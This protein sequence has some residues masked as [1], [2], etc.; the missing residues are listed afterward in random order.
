MSKQ[1]RSLLD[2]LKE[3]AEV[4]VS[5]AALV[6]AVAA[7]VITLEQTK[8]MREEAELERRNARIGVM[9]SVWVGTHIG[10]SAG[11]AYFRIVLTNKG[12][13]PAVIERVDVDYKGKP[14]GN[15]DEL[16]RRMAADLGSAKD[17]EGDVLFSSR[18]PVSPGLMLEAGGDAVPLNVVE[19]GD[20]EG[21][22]LLIRGTPHLQVTLCYCSLYGDCFRTEL[23]RRPQQ[24]DAC[25][26]A[27]KPFIS[28]GFFR[29]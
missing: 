17:F 4:L 20:A 14:V 26:A 25:E 13:G 29:N 24:V 22:K 16:A 23:F 28:H 10:D 19:S 21:L 27:E 9:P 5:G 3:Y 12:L 11:E 2:L 15:W 6:T 1:R 7:V 18:S 8:V